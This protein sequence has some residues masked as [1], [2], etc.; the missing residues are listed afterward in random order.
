M[1]TSLVYVINHQEKQLEGERNR[2]ANLENDLEGKVST[3]MSL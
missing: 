1:I 2:A 3:L